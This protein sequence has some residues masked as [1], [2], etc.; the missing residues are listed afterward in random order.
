MNVGDKISI[1]GLIGIVRYVGEYH[2]KPGIFVGVELEK[3]KGKNNGTIKGKKYFECP[4]NCGLFVDLNTAKSIMKIVTDDGDG[5]QSPRIDLKSAS[6]NQQISKSVDTVNA[7]NKGQLNS[8]LKN[9]Q[10]PKGSNQSVKPPVEVHSARDPAVT[11]SKPRGKSINVGNSSSHLVPEAT[12]A[13]SAEKATTAQSSVTSTAKTSSQPNSIP[14]KPIPPKR[15]SMGPPQVNNGPPPVASGAQSARAPPATAAKSNSSHAASK[16]NSAPVTADPSKSSL[17]QTSA[18]A[19]SQTS[20]SNAKSDSSGKVQSARA[21]SNPLLQNQHQIPQSAREPQTKQISNPQKPIDQQQQQ[22]QQQS[23]PSHPQDSPKSPKPAIPLLSI[24]QIQIDEPPII[25]SQSSVSFDEIKN[26]IPDSAASA[27]VSVNRE[28]QSILSQGQSTEFQATSASAEQSSTETSPRV[29]KPII[30]PEIQAKIKELNSKYEGYIKQ[31]KIIK[32]KLFDIATSYKKKKEEQ[33][34]S[35]KKFAEEALNKKAELQ[36]NL[37]TEIN[38]LETQILECLERT[39]RYLEIA[40]EQRANKVIELLRKINEEHVNFE[41]D[42]DIF[43]NAQRINV[44]KATQSVHILNDR[45]KKVLINRQVNEKL[46]N[47]KKSIM[48]EKEKE[49]ADKRPR[50]QE[51][52]KLRTTFSELSEKVNHAK[53]ISLYKNAEREGMRRFYQ[54]FSDVPLLNSLYL[55]LCIEKKTNN[56]EIRHICEL[57]K[58]VLS[59]FIAPTAKGID[60]FNALSDVDSAIEKDEEPQSL[61]VELAL[62]E[63]SSVRLDSAL[64]SFK[65]LAGA[66]N[67]KDEKLK[68]QVLELASEIKASPIIHPALLE[69]D[70]KEDFAEIAKNLLFEIQKAE[71]DEDEEEINLD[72][73]KGQLE[74]FNVPEIDIIKGYTDFI[75]PQQTVQDK[76]KVSPEIAKKRQERKDIESKSKFLEDEIVKE[77]AKFEA[78]RDELNEP[79]SLYMELANQLEIT[80]KKLAKYYN[81]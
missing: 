30:T 72:Q 58:F 10:Q 8:I 34:K 6:Q 63:I 36:I 68:N 74:K 37:E 66:E 26:R 18:K 65:L 15:A 46:I 31:R 25:A 54:M 7:Q 23:Q 80:K 45:L 17:T 40:D 71:D 5:S 81:Q 35:L 77:K 16:N 33:E 44:N 14:G 73:F 27:I 59:G 9:Q 69:N 38:D 49:L 13:P 60:L 57:T 43:I 51:V 24:P 39:H 76:D 48:D 20:L 28:R 62:E 52:T 19:E 2:E 29:A 75:L 21:P 12:P 61:D 70:K 1:K 32:Q 53:K 42:L 4:E 22:Q 55:I 11:F 50:W 79:M 56:N 67:I 41:S 64:T 78:L 47:K 3:P